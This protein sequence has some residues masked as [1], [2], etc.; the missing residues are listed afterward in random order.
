MFTPL[1][2]RSAAE[3]SIRHCLSVNTWQLIQ[4]QFFFSAA[5]HLAPA[6]FDYKIIA[7]RLK[8]NINLIRREI[9]GASLP[10][11]R[12]ATGTKAE[13]ELRGASAHAHLV[14]RANGNPKIEFGKSARDSSSESDVLIARSSPPSA[15]AASTH[16]LGSLRFYGFV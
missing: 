1:G 14:C 5:P 10:R 4:A 8:T 11:K 15:A 3:P 7:S 12:V 9:A 6:E 13:A 16:S 2:R